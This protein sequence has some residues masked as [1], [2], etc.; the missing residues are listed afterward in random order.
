MTD[1]VDAKARATARGL[2]QGYIGLDHKALDVW[3]FY[4]ALVQ[5]LREARSIRTN[6]PGAR[7]GGTHRGWEPIAV[8]SR[9]LVSRTAMLIL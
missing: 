2:I 5:L 1:G 4:A 9:R 7:L 8:E 3:V 6:C